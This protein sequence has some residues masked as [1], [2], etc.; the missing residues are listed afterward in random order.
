MTTNHRGCTPR[1]AAAEWGP[2]WSQTAFCPPSHTPG[3]AHK[4]HRQWT[5]QPGDSVVPSATH[6]P[7]RLRRRCGDNGALLMSCS[8]PGCPHLVP[9]GSDGRAPEGLP[10]PLQTPPS[11]GAP[12]ASQTP[13]AG[14]TRGCSSPTPG[15][16]PSA[17][18]LPSAGR[19]GGSA[20]SGRGPRGHG[21][22][23]GEGHGPEGRG[24]RL[25]PVAGSVPAPARLEMLPRLGFIASELGGCA[26]GNGWE[27]GGSG[28]AQGLNQPYRN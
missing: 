18:P 15:A 6:P 12:R 25:A 3:K 5:P 10:G 8:A 21:G 20:P 26:R 4:L 2:H 27:A 11:R 7:P 1:D 22:A 23:S 16:A 9:T 19:G 13:R 14:S 28:V 24:A 17:S